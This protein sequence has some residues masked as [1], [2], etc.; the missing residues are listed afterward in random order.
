MPEHFNEVGAARLVRL[1][2]ASEARAGGHA[3]LSRDDD[4]GGFSKGISGSD[5]AGEKL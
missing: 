3:L 4:G 2:R 1:S 5:Q